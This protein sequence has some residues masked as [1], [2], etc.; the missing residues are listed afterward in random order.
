M[1]K[2]FRVTKYASKIAQVS[3]K[4][5]I[6]GIGILGEIGSDIALSCIS[7]RES[8]RL[9]S[10]TSAIAEKISE[11]MGQRLEAGDTPNDLSMVNYRE[12]FINELLIHTLT[13]CRDEPEAKKN[14]FTENVFVNVLFDNS[15]FLYDHQWGHSAIKDIE[16]FTYNQILLFNLVC[17]SPVIISVNEETYEDYISIFQSP[18]GVEYDRN[19]FYQSNQQLILN[20]FHTLY[21]MQYLMEW[22]RIADL[23]IQNGNLSNDRYPFFCGVIPSVVKGLRIKELFFSDTNIP[24]YL[25]QD[26]SKLDNIICVKEK[27]DYY[28]KKYL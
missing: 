12:P 2:V 6:K 26:T 16:R 23:H 27:L 3:P 1:E 21:D 25:K 28:I 13:K 11:K 7:Q 22:G 24:E 14:H 4:P 10:S 8:S 9:K 5:I 17:S 19:N 15:K 20:D 18:F